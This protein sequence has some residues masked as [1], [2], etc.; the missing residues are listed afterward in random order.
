MTGTRV[1]AQA[2]NKQ[3]HRVSALALTSALLWSGAASAQDAIPA[4]VA[5][6]PAQASVP[7][8][9]SAAASADIIVTGS[10][11]S[12]STFNSPSPVTVLGGEE[13]ERLAITNVGEGIS[14][15][16]SFRA[17]TSPTT[18]GFNSF[19][20]G[21]Q[22]VN[23]RG[24]GVTRNLILV[25][26]RRFAPTTREGSVD[27]NFIPSILV[28]RT[29]VVT[30][31]ASAAYGSDAIAG[32]VNIILDKRLDGFKG[33]ADIG[34][35]DE[36]DGRNYHGALAFGT[37]FG[38]G[39]GHFVIG[40][41]YDKQL[42]IGNCFT[43]DW[44]TAAAV[45]TNPNYNNPAG[46]GNGL[47]NYV[48]DDNNA[49][50]FFNPA[51]VIS[52]VNNP[53]AVGLAAQIRNLRGTGAIT[54]D[55][56]G[57]VVARRTG[58]L[59]FATQ[60]IGGD[61]YPTYSSANITVPVERYTGFAH[62]DYEFSDALSGFVEASY[63]HVDGTVLQTGYFGSAVAIY[64]DNVF[65]PQEIRNVIGPVATRPVAQ[66]ALAFNL[67]RSLDD[68]GRGLSRSK[69]D[70]YRATAGLNGKFSD[71]W[72]WDAYYQYGRTDRLQTVQNNLIIAKFTNATDAVANPATGQPICRALLS[73]DAAVRAAAAGCQPLNLF[74]PNRASQAAL[75][76]MYGTL[77]EKIRL[78]Q[79]VV[80]GNVRGELGGDLLAGPLAVALGGEYR[81]DT[82]DVAHDAL[83]N[84][85]AY[86][87]NF[88][89]DYD[90]KSKVV[91]GYVEAE[92]PLI[93]D[94]S[95]TKALSL[96]GAVRQVHY[97]IS[98]FGSYLRTAT[99]NKFDVTAWKVSANWELNDWIRFRASRSRDLRAPNFAELYLASA[100]AFTPYL[101]R[102]ANN[103]SITPSTLSGGSPDL[104]PEKADTKSL[105]VIF[106]PQSLLK[107][108]RLSVDYYDIKVNGYIASPGGGQIIIDRCFAGI[109]EA[110]T[111]IN[112]GG[113]PG[114]AGAI[115]SI[116]NT[117]TNL[118]Q[119][120][121]KGLDFEA[122]Y[123]IGLAS[124]N[125]I[126]LR[127]LASYV[128]SLETSLFGRSIDRA[129]QTGNTGGAGGALSAAPKWTVSGTVTYSSPVFTV[130]A[131]GRYIDSGLYDAERIGPD[132]AGYAP[133]LLNSINDNRVESRF[134]VN[135][136]A[137]INVLA[138]TDRK[139]EIFGSVNNLFDKAPPAAPETQF[140]TNPVYFDTIGRYYR[141]G[142]RFKM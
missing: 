121:A 7:A 51:G 99:S 31:G 95:F 12:R 59:G 119:I 61:V 123:R 47:P 88:G 103:A 16:P 142:A 105:G 70:N 68:L 20:V 50:F 56:A 34:I 113:G 137:S 141:V 6:T 65:L 82:I 73:P 94:A 25:D 127:G 45:V 92:L 49:G 60:Q 125:S 26:G 18:Q 27:L 72:S 129:G 116:R 37:A 117:S 130:T 124:G 10:R 52:N 97:D 71:A 42:G 93:R 57:N 33:Q 38:G 35:S 96:N 80:A 28:A 48:R 62:A 17:S 41:E 66:R 84:S 29:E 23:L 90:G 135:L 126:L 122:D 118:D 75:G 106:T 53:A 13:F 78:Q 69:A 110:C 89:A 101:N 63:G 134:Y 102:F 39:A 109:A 46:V 114:A 4:D 58:S 83:S 86:F 5:T 1:R 15:L 64:T 87:Q 79:H 120:R 139:F 8:E 112:G 22:I 131:Q 104:A 136:N 19:N 40:G 3:A 55:A 24:I 44:C 67:G 85:F 21:A 81:V 108:F 98:G 128:D 14:E 133:T 77:V 76:Y 43:R 100:G 32:A 74:G 2:R 36:G 107:G 140:Y 132:Q 115:T 9:T 11:L 54:F 111:L 30:G 91:E 138:D